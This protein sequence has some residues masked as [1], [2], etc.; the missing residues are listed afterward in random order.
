MNPN[1]KILDKIRN[2]LELAEDGNQDEESQTALLMAQKLMLKHKI[3]QQ[4]LDAATS[5]DAIVTRS[6][7][8]YKTLFWWEKILARTIADYSIATPVKNPT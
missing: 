2:L 5:L 6:L 7:S 8:V 3:S 4:E 1:D